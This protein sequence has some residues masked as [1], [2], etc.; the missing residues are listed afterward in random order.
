MPTGDAGRL[1]CLAALAAYDAAPQE[2]DVKER[3]LRLLEEVRDVTDRGSRTAHVTA[4]ALP[5]SR[6]GRRVL[7][8]RHPRYGRW[9]PWGGHV[10][11]DDRDVAGAVVRELTE[12][13]GDLGWAVHGLVGLWEGPVRCQADTEVRHLDLLLAVTASDAREPAL[14]AEVRIGGWFDVD[15]LPEPQVPALADLVRRTSD[16]RAV[17]GAGSPRC[18]TR[19]GD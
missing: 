14:A 11:P 4:S 18:A 12:E 2:R 9:G 5:L 15:A 16:P 7:L 19:R 13:A 1:A 8:C 6:D 17:P 10:D 3:W